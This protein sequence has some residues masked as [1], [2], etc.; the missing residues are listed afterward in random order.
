MT[1][2]IDIRNLICGSKLHVTSTVDLTVSVSFQVLADLYEII[3]VQYI[4]L[5]SSANRQT[6]VAECPKGGSDEICFG[7]GTCE[8]VMIF[9]VLK[10]DFKTNAL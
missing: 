4:N 3:V 6:F 8:V 2:V 5:S 10:F 7:R 1:C 9:L